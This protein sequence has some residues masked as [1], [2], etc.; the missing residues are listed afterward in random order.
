MLPGVVLSTPVLL[1]CRG[2]LLVHAVPNVAFENIFFTTGI[3]SVCGVTTIRFDGGGK[4]ETFLMVLQLNNFR[5]K[6]RC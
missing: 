3:I 1:T 6:L 2:V 4:E 5:P